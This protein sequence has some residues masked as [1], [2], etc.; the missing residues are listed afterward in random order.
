LELAPVQNSTTMYVRYFDWEG[1]KKLIPQ[2][3]GLFCVL[4]QILVTG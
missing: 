2:Q 1:K 4:A 3:A